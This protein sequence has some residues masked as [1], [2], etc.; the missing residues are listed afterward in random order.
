MFVENYR[1][2]CNKLDR[3]ISG[4]ISVTAIN[5]RGGRVRAYTFFSFSG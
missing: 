1:L 3:I 4:L 2:V 5:H